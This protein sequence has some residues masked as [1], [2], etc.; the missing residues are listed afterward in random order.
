LIFLTSRYIATRRNKHT[1]TQIDV[2]DFLNSIL[3]AIYTS[4]LGVRGS[5][6]VK[7]L[8]YKPESR[9]FGEAIF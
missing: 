4:T 2:K 9:G 5:V 3:F 8:C 6:V 1:E 7:A